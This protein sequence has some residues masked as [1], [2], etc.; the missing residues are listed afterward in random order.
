MRVAITGGIGSGK[1]HVCRLL[2]DLGIKV[3]DCDAAAKRLMTTDETIW[4]QLSTLVSP[5]VYQGGKIN[6]KLLAE[7]ILRS[8]DN[9]KAVNNVVH[10]AV[11]RDFMQSNYDWLESAI[12]FESGFHLRVPLNFI[13]CISATKEL[14]AER[15][16]RRDNI[17]HDKAMQW[18]DA[19]MPQEE[20]EALS[21]FVI[22]NDGVRS[23]EN[24]IKELFNYI[25][26]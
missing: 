2:E 9:K 17:S 16:M 15:I 8:D 14:R 7:F 3:Y 25:N 11:A 23:V 10:P 6:K 18:I 19:Q 13:V 26:Q 4:Q 1:T 24:Q 20:I 12:L 22:V 5:Q 21:D